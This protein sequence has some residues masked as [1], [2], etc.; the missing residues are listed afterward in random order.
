[1]AGILAG[2]TISFVMSK[3]FAFRSRSL[4]RAPAEMA[5]FLIVYAASCS[6][7]WGMAVALERLGRECRFS[8]SVAEAFGVLAGAGAMT[9]TSYLGHRFF[10]YRT[11]RHR[12]DGLESAG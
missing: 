9:V 12:V 2:L 7:Y 6:F 10:T 11:H 8:E 5:R 4:K 3:W 1:L